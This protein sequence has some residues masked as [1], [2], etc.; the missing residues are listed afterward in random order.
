MSNQTTVSMGILG[1]GTFMLPCEFTC[2]SCMKS[3]SLDNTLEMKLAAGE[4]SDFAI[5]SICSKCGHTF[6]NPKIK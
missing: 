3:S 2:E 6:L 5:K 1:P 4:T